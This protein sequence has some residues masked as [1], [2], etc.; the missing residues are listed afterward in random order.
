MPLLLLALL[1]CDPSPIVTD[2]PTACECVD[3]DPITFTATATGGFDDWGGA[4]LVYA[5][6]EQAGRVLVVAMNYETGVGQIPMEPVCESPDTLVNEWVVGIPDGAFEDVAR[7][8]LLGAALTTD[9]GVRSLSQDVGALLLE[10]D[11]ASATPDRIHVSTDGNVTLLRGDGGGDTLQG[12]LTF[13]ALADGVPG[14]AEPA[15]G[16]A[17]RLGALDLSWASLGPE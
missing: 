12:A 8:P 15:C 5:V 13:A 7:W 17:L 4:A 2:A 1:G 16:R 11:L 10:G 14:H 3:P 9:A 6:D